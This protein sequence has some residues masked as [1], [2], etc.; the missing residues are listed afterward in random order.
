MVFECHARE[1]ITQALRAIG[2]AG[3][4]FK[5]WANGALDAGRSSAPDRAIAPPRSSTCG[6][7]R[8]AGSA[9]PA[10]AGLP[11]ARCHSSAPPPHL[12][13]RA[14]ARRPGHLRESG[15]LRARVHPIPAALGASGASFV[16]PTSPKPTRTPLRS[17]RPTAGPRRRRSPLHAT[18]TTIQALPEPAAT[19][20][21][22]KSGN[23]PPGR[24]PM[25]R[26]A[27]RKEK[28]GAIVGFRRAGKPTCRSCHRSQNCSSRPHRSSCR[29][30]C[31][32]SSPGRIPDPG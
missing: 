23:A 13:D 1:N 19:A 9:T 24:S 27:C 5:R 16:S 30:R 32:R 14:N 18:K 7:A 26:C 11:R 4:P 28:I 6:A 3:D 8:Q 25:G 31:S 12:P 29:V 22:R 21:R 17:S 15:T 20:G 10:S 2:R